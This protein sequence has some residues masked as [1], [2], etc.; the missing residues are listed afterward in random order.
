MLPLSRRRDPD[1]EHFN[2]MLNSYEEQAQHRCDAIPVEVAR[3]MFVEY[4]R[5]FHTYAH[6]IIDRLDDHMRSC[7]SPSPELVTIRTGMMRDAFRQGTVLHCERR[8]GKTTALFDSAEE[9]ASQTQSH[10]TIISPHKENII[11]EAARRRLRE[12]RP[13]QFA[14]LDFVGSEELHSLRGCGQEVMV[15]DWF[16]ISEKARETLKNHFKIIA[17]VGT[18]PHCTPIPITDY[19]RTDEALYLGK[20]IPDDIELINPIQR[21]SRKT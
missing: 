9:V 19:A 17:A 8:S 15:D 18:F 2:R 14:R 12:G 10:I 13:H 1:E 7:T 21:W 11:A 20:R 16:Q 4:A 3:E 5:R 6:N